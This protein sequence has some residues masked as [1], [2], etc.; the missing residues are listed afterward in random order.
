MKTIT[1][2][3]DERQILLFALTDRANRM[4]RDAEAYKRNGN[5]AAMKDCLNEMA[6]A[7]DLAKLI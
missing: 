7:N 3:D 5:K 1:I 4:F 2:S 6:K